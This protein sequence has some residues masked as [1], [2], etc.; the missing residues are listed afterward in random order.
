MSR[1]QL[2]VG[3]IEILVLFQKHLAVKSLT[4]MNMGPFNA[5]IVTTLVVLGLLGP[6]LAL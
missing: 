4:C 1:G 6:R 3:I 5:L 2:E